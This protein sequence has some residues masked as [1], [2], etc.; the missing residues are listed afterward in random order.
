MFD[1]SITYD[2]YGGREAVFSDLC[3]L[4]VLNTNC[5]KCGNPCKFYFLGD[6]SMP[7]LR[8]RCKY[9]GSSLN[10]SH[11]E[12]HAIE[13][14]PLFLFVLKCYILRVQ[15]KAI[16]GLTGSKME[17]VG[18]YPNV[19]RDSVCFAFNETARD[20][21]FMFGGEGKVVEVDEAF[22][23]HSKNHRGRPE[24]KEGYWVVGITEVDQNSHR[25]ENE[26]L[27]EQMKE[28]EDARE[29]AAE[30]ELAR[31]GKCK[32]R[33]RAVRVLRGPRLR[34]TTQDVLDEVESFDRQIDQTSVDNTPPVPPR[35]EQPVVDVENEFK[36]I[37]QKSRK[38]QPKKT[39]FFVVE[40]RDARTLE[41]IIA[42]YV[43]PGSTIHTDEWPGYSGLVAMGYDHKTICHKKRFSRLIFEDETATL[44]TTNHIERMWVEMRK[45]MK[46]MKIVQFEKYLNLE[47]Y[48]LMNL[49]G[50][51]EENFKTAL[52]DVGR[53]G[54]MIEKK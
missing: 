14:I 49:Y 6:R 5:P 31:R 1:F 46:V 10:G 38:G 40:H 27:L 20:E 24:A 42:E 47:P 43:I 45:T 12:K 13:D 18:K 52:K 15:T 4:G 35:S 11:F 25:I 48:R 28:R 37:F 44:I 21:N 51:T 3:E 29:N 34:R 50:T 30:A 22:V 53:F 23:C 32:T 19:I 36:A 7:Q 17:T 41:K 33:K 8:C 2:S 26:V 9:R 54:K 39:I 16:V